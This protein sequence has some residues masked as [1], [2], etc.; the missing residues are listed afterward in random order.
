MIGYTNIMYVE[1]IPLPHT[2]VSEEAK[3]LAEWSDQTALAIISF[4]NNLL[5]RPLRHN[6]LNTVKLHG[7]YEVVLLVRK[8][9]LTWLEKKSILAAGAHNQ[10]FVEI[11][12]KTGRNLA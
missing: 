12:C 10:L 5:P 3:R 8:C 2:T 1:A 7:V 6:L 9:K 4:N 11:V